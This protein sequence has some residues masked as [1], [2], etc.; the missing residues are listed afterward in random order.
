MKHTFVH[1]GR[2]ITYQYEV[3]KTFF[4]TCVEFIEIQRTC[5]EEKDTIILKGTFPKN[6]LKIKIKSDAIYEAW[7]A[8]S[9]TPQPILAKFPIANDFI[10]NKNI[11]E[12]C[13]T[14]I[15]YV[16]GIS[17]ENYVPDDRDFKGFDYDLCMSIELVVKAAHEFIKEYQRFKGSRY[18]KVIRQ[19]LKKQQKDI[20]KS[21]Q[22]RG[23]A[24]VLVSGARIISMFTGGGDIGSSASLGSTTETTISDADFTDWMDS[25]SI[26]GQPDLD[27]DDKLDYLSQEGDESDI[28]FTGHTALSCNICGCKQYVPR[29]SGKNTGSDICICGH[30]CSDHEWKS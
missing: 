7:K 3:K 17:F 23:L 14:D 5:S 28:S 24:M 19:L 15:E 18:I 29:I 2:T 10:R 16:T 25:L 13:V 20:E 1:L 6:K 30:K 26:D 9:I 11:F 4:N 21:G 22:L 27:L 8:F 12:L